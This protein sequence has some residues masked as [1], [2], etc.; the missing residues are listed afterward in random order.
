MADILGG[1]VEPGLYADAIASELAARGHDDA[2]V[3]EATIGY[4][5]IVR[6]GALCV[7][8]RREWVRAAWTIDGPNALWIA[9]AGQDAADIAAEVERVLQTGPVDDRAPAWWHRGT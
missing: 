9:R 1:A 4:S 3:T 2:R 6:V 5:A 8:V 7:V